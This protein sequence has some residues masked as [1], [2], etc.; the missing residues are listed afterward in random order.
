MGAKAYRML[1]EKKRLWQEFYQL[2]LD[3]AELLA[4]DRG[5]ELLQLLDRK[6]DCIKALAE[7]EEQLAKE[8]GSAAAEGEINKLEQEIYELIEAC[9]QADAA[10]RQKIN[11]CYRE[12]KQRLEHLQTGRRAVSGYNKALG[13]KK[14]Y[15]VDINR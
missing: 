11:D 15:F 10:N 9:R 8:G 2:T 12:L 4:P 3:Q 5:A 7:L 1:A 13:A 14:G 6:D